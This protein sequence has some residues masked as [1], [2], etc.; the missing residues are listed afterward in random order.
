MSSASRHRL[1][2]ASVVTAGATLLS[3]L[4]WTPFWRAPAPPPED[5]HW[6]GDAGVLA[7]DGRMGVRDG[8]ASSA[9]F[10]DP[11]GVAVAPDGGLLVADGVDAHRIRRI[12]PD[13]RVSTVAGGARG[14]NDGPAA[15]ARF[16]TPSGV[17]VGADGSVYVAD[18]GNNA[19]RRIA[20]D[21]TVS[22]LAGGGQ[23]GL[24]DGTGVNARFNGPLAVAAGPDGK[25]FV[26][27]TYNDRIRVLTSDGRVTTLAGSGGFGLLDGPAAGARFDT[28]CGIAG[29]RRQVGYRPLVRCQTADSS[30]RWELPSINRAPCSWPRRVD[31]SSRSGPV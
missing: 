18:T 20:P 24:A 1:V 10:S 22:T 28:P 23:S 12:G 17:A 25:L 19:I 29:S 11:F 21:G 5:D 26:A 14:L 31:A 15:G 13:G 6:V 30:D 27:D 7:G 3:W 4:L 8:E 16:D 9:R 2:A